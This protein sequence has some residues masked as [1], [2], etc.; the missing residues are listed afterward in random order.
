VNLKFATTKIHKKDLA[1][2]FQKMSMLLDTGYD[3]CSAAE[4]L[5]LT[6]GKK[7]HDHSADGVRKVANLLLPS[8]RE[9]FQLH[10]AMANHPKQ[11]AQYTK[12]V[13]VGEESEKLVEVTQRISDEIKNSTKIM[14]K[15]KSALAYPAF[16]LVFTVGVAIY[17]FTSVVPNIISMLAEVGS[18]EIPATTQLVMNFGDFLRSYGLIVFGTLALIIGVLVVYGKTA[19]QVQMAQLS[20]HVPFLGKIVQNNSMS[21]FFKNWQQMIL[22]GAEMSIALESAAEAVGNKYIKRQL[23]YSYENYTENGVPVYEALKN[24]S[25]IREL[26]LQT[27]MVAIEG[28]KIGRTLGILA[29]DREYEA[30][31]GI[32]AFTAAV[33]PILLIIVGIIVA[34][35]VLAIYQPIIAISSVLQ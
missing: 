16:V 4:L 26:E 27:L 10:E 31:K 18:T 1:E 9:G 33:N 11:F 24:V 32:N 17:L 28:N 3:I 6:T 8:L 22:A 15:L 21:I 13:Q 23:E 14:N 2:F 20:T 5:S 35:I 34:I 7:S 12:Q 30:Q 29:E 19:G 25:C